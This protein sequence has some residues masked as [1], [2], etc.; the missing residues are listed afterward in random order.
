MKFISRKDM[1]KKI[2]QIKK[3]ATNEV[4]FSDD[5]SLGANE[6]ITCH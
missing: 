4:C 6:L 5:F 2:I 3:L 1:P